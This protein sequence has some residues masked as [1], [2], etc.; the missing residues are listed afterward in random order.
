VASVLR[1]DLYEVVN[2]MGQ[3]SHESRY[4][5]QHILFYYLC[6]SQP[7]VQE[8]PA[9]DGFWPPVFACN[10]LQSWSSLFLASL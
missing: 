9:E 2:Q 5:Q 1:V 6:D 4:G 3:H 10:L 8:K 7:G